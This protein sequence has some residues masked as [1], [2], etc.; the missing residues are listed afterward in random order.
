MNVTPDR[1]TPQLWLFTIVTGAAL[2]PIAQWAQLRWPDEHRKSRSSWRQWA[3]FWRLI[4]F[5]TATGI[6]IVMIG[7]S[8][9]AEAD[10][11]Q[12]L[13]LTVALAAGMQVVSWWRVREHFLHTDLIKRG[14]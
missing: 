10:V 1:A 2:A 12:F 3:M 4:I 6:W 11:R 13:L 5:T 9:G 8:G 14:A 7:D